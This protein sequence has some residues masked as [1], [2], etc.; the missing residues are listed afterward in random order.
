MKYSLLKK[1]FLP[2]AVGGM[3]LSACEKVETPEPIGTGGQKIFS[4]IDFGGT[5]ANY[6]NSALVFPDPSATSVPMD[7]QVEY[8]TPVVSDADIDIT[9]G[10]DAAAVAKYNTANP[11]GPQYELLPTNAYTLT[12]T[13]GKIAAKQTVSSPFTITY[14]PSVIDVSKNYMLPITIKT[15]AGAPA[16]AKTASGTGTA[17]FHLIGNPLAGTYIVTGIR[18]NYATNVP[19]A[20]GTFNGDP[21]NIPA[22]YISTTAI[23]TPKLASPVDGNTIAID[24]ANLGPNGF[25]YL[26]TQTGNFASIDIGFNDLVL[27]GNTI[28]KKFLVSY[29]A[30]NNVTHVKA[31]FRI[32]TQYNNNP[33]N[34]GSDRILDETFEQQ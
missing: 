3:L 22:G 32:I 9:I 20:S 31:K 6:P 2:L 13:T 10:I 12:T 21:A 11:T 24:F 4:F 34:T 8:S 29:T 19:G 30:P 1:I 17:Y 25:Q 28:Y 7:F 18:Y 16:D 23:P 14:N 27:G 15:V 26:L 5:T 33:T